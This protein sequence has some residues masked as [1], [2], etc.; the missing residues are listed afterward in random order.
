M[1]SRVGVELIDICL[2][3]IVLRIFLLLQGRKDFKKFRFLAVY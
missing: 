3:E 2:V 1:Q